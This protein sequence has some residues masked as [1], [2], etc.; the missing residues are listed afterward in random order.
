MRKI[1]LLTLLLLLCLLSTNILGQ[2]TYTVVG[3]RASF[4]MSTLHG[5]ETYARKS[6][7][8]GTGIYTDSPYNTALF[9]AWDF[10]FTI[11]YMRDNLMIQGDFTFAT[12]ANVKLTNA[13]ISGSSLNRIRLHYNNLNIIGG[14]KIP[15]NENF[16][17]IM[18]L[19]PYIGFDMTA[20]LSGR[21]PTYGKGNNSTSF[22]S[23]GILDAEEADYKQSDFGG[24]VLAGVEFNNIQIALNYQHGLKNIVKDD[25]PLYNRIYR[26]STIY[27]F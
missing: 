3:F 24:M 25:Y 16:R 12:Y 18:G 4:G 11:Q 9:P 21:E 5:I 22:L 14:T 19:G 7:V 10:G 27:F 20:W 26:I 1:L 15:V 6:R 23:K 13:K 2:E 8:P 17:F